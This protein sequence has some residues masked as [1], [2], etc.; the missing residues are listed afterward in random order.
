MMTPKK[1]KMPTGM[2]VSL[3][4]AANAKARF[5]KAKSMGKTTGPPKS[6]APSKPSALKPL[7][8]KKGTPTGKMVNLP[9]KKGTPT[10]KIKM[11]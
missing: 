6:A 11:Y 10:G 9:K 8:K 4:D 3:K 1:P 7:P 2:K 5:A